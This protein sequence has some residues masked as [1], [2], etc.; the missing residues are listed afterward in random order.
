MTVA[1]F[2]QQCLFLTL[3]TF[4]QFFLYILWQLVTFFNSLWCFS[5]VLF[6]FFSTVGDFFYFFNSWLP[7]WHFYFYDSDFFWQL[8]TFLTFM[9]V[10][11]FFLLFWQGDRNKIAYFPCS[12]LLQASS[13]LKDWFHSSHFTALSVAAFLF[14]HVLFRTSGSALYMRMLKTYPHPEGQQ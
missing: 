8:M 10:G 13:M 1:D 3:S 9:K 6:Y 12:F 4:P 2:F 11:N 5:M 14:H 7:F